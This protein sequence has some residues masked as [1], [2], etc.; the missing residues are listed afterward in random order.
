[1]RPNAPFPANTRNGLPG[2]M[3]DPV[4]SGLG[5]SAATW[6]GTGALPSSLEKGVRALG[7][8]SEQAWLPRRST[9][10]AG[11]GC[12]WRSRAGNRGQQTGGQR[13]ADLH[14]TLVSS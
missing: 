13:I 1:M 6:S 2:K 5:Y 11:H 4:A 12:V 10:P 3:I 9:C 7:L 14:I 8:R